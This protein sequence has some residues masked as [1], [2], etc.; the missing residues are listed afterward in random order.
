MVYALPM[1]AFGFAALALLMYVGN[2]RQ[3]KRPEA[4][5]GETPSISV[6]IPARNEE[7]GIAACVES[8]L[9]NCDVILEVIVL[10]DG[11]TDRTADLVRGI[12]AR[13][14]RVRLEPAP[15]LPPGWAGKQHACFALSKLAKYD[16]FTFLD[17]DVRLSDTALSRLHG[18]LKTSGAALVSGFPRQ[19]TKTLLE[20]LI[21]PLI[22]WL[23]L[24]YLPISRMRKSLQPGLGA[25]CGQWFLTT[26]EAYEKVGGHEAVKTS[27]HDGLKLPR[28]YRAAGLM[29]DFCDATHDATCRMY[30]TAGQ[31]WNGFAK[32]AREG[33]AGNVQIWVW[34]LLLA[35][36]HLLP[37]ALLPTLDMMNDTWPLIP[38][39]CVMSVLPRFDAAFRF[40]QPLLGAMLHPLAV[41]GLLGIQW[42]AAVR[43]WLGKPVGW[44]GRP[45]PAQGTTP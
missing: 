30:R 40:R 38:A 12:A 36:G 6:L 7:R 34:T 8:V 22:N 1:L 5:A 33:M 3:F 21:I 24:C 26:R 2:I 44:K 14:S 9:A 16:T 25:G 13:D 28:A 23:L 19:E 42:Y 45:L 37:F 43:A 11:S 39:A 35:G 32:N 27:F 15:P 10:D 20:I 17:A 31:V 4:V 18:F 29:T 41:F